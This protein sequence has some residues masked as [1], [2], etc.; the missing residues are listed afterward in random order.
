MR[1]VTD[2]K[3]RGIQW[4]MISRLEDLDLQMIFAY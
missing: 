1:K 2:E 4:G 3:K